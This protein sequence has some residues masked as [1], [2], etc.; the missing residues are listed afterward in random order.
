ME[1]T[2]SPLVLLLERIYLQKVH[3]KPNKWVYNKKVCRNSLTV[4]SMKLRAEKG[5]KAQILYRQMCARIKLSKYI[6]QSISLSHF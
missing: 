6:V 4:Q 1:R 3:L 5:S 2:F